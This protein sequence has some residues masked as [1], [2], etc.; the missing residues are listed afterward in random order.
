MSRAT[1][2]Q[3]RSTSPSGTGRTSELWRGYV[4]EVYSDETVQLVVPRLGGDAPIGRYPALVRN[5]MIGAN[6]VVGAVEGR[7]DDLV[8]LAAVGSDGLIVGDARFTYVLLD[9]EPT[10]PKHAVT[11][12]YA[13]GLGSVL[14]GNDTIVRRGASGSIIANNVYL[15]NSQT[16]GA[17]ATSKT[18]VDTGDAARMEKTPI[19]L[20]TTM[21]DLNDFV[22][23]GNYHQGFNATANT[24]LNYPLGVAGWLTVM[25]V[26]ST[27]IYQWYVTYSGATR[28]FWRAKYNTQAWGGWNEVAQASHIH[29]NATAAVAGFMSPSDKAKLDAAATAATGSTLVLR[30]AAGRAKFATPAASDDAATMGYVDGQIATRAAASHTHAASEISDSTATGRSVLSAASAAAARTAIGA[31]TSSLVIGTTSTTAKAGNWF[32]SFAD[33]T[34]VISTAQ[35]PPLAINETYP[36]ASQAAMLALTAQRGDMA[37]RSD[38]GRTYVLSSDAPATLADW[39][40]IMAAGQVQSVAGKTGVVLLVKADVGLDQVDNTS[41]LNKPVS[42]ATQTALNGKANTAHTHDAADI[43]GGVLAAARLP[44][45]TTAAQG[46][47]SA[48]DKTMLNAASAAATANTLVKLDGFGRAQVAAPAVAADIANKAYA[49]G[50]VADSGWVNCTLTA[51]WVNYDAGPHA[52]LQV[53]KIGNIVNIKG[54]I[55]SGSL[56][57]NFGV[58]PAGYRPAEQRWLTSTFQ[59]SIVGSTFAV[60]YPDGTL[61]FVGSG[62]VTYISVEG[63]YFI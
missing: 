15:G 42:T 18:Y 43:T 22:T 26:G 28:V 48:A 46:A 12:A 52:T 8:V 61:F 35:L 59:S 51:P 32:P 31:G 38:N 39:K 25:A 53:R 2:R 34:G 62:A 44:A 20:P 41:D 6:V 36:V 23:S 37:I 40:E 58:V 16:T 1:V 55:K 49:D 21:H 13:D 33:V 60:V 54:F 9:N 29:A 45:A 5:L 63:T 11:K 27:F 10:D 4:S 3:G 14:G 50:L 19:A 17:A 57:T 56:G 24:S 7:V 47:L 30:D